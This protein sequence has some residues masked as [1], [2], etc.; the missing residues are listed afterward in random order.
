MPQTDDQLLPGWW[1]FSVRIIAAVPPKLYSGDFFISRWAMVLH[2]STHTSKIHWHWFS[3]TVQKLF[4]S[5]VGTKHFSMWPFLHLHKQILLT[6]QVSCLC[7]VW[8]ILL[9]EWPQ[10]IFGTA[11]LPVHCLCTAAA[12]QGNLQSY[13]NSPGEQLS[14]L[15]K[16]FTVKPVAQLSIVSHISALNQT[17]PVPHGC[18][19]VPGVPREQWL[20]SLGVHTGKSLPSLNSSSLCKIHFHFFNQ[21]YKLNPITLATVDIFGNQNLGIRTESCIWVFC[22]TEPTKFLMQN[23]VK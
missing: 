13:S 1:L 10:D 5:P 15:V 20:S 9:Q 21:I 14:K 18:W 4:P 11:A 19:G 6:I 12:A 3:S 7:S 8:S 23:K 17:S 16:C 2:N 22:Q